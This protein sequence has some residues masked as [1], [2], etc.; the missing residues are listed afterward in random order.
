MRNNLRV[1]TVDGRKAYFHC[2]EDKAEI[3][4]PA[5][6]T[7]G[8]CG[9]VVRCILAIVEYIDDGTVQEVYPSR[10]VFEHER[11]DGMVWARCVATSAKPVH[12]P[13]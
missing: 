8:H 9:G 1:C 7:G 2:W 5:A 3:I 6:G 10:I 4:P 11:K 13:K 12:P